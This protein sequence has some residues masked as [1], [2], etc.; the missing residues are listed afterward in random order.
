[1]TQNESFPPAILSPHTPR[2]GLASASAAVIEGRSLEQV[3]GNCG[4]PMIV[5]QPSAPPYEPSPR[6]PGQPRRKESGEM[7][8]R[9]PGQLRRKES[10]VVSE[11]ERAYRKRRKKLREANGSSGEEGSLCLP[12]KTEAICEG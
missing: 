9:V 8:D 11:R 12:P 3:A 2:F 5:P 7:G 6:V 4:R 1:M 10:G